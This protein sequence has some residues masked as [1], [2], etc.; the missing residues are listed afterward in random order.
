MCFVAEMIERVIRF[1]FCFFCFAIV[2]FISR[3]ILLAHF[4]C[5]IFL[6]PRTA[7]RL[8]MLCSAHRE[9][10]SIAVIQQWV[11][12]CLWYRGGVPFW[13]KGFSHLGGSEFPARPHLP[14]F[15]HRRG[16]GPR[17]AGIQ[18]RHGWE[19]PM[20]MGPGLLPRVSASLGQLGGS[21]PGRELDHPHSAQLAFPNHFSN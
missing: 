2:L 8:L 6:T 21:V 11:G 13:L 14:K 10:S 5:I 4:I 17:Q 7:V 19:P 20:V 12:G 9:S 16:H 3:F 18:W 1:V 15:L